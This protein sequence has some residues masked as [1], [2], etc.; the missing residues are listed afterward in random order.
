[1]NNGLQEGKQMAQTKD[2]HSYTVS[3]TGDIRGPPQKAPNPQ[4][5]FPSPGG[6]FAKVLG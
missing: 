1:M 2:R 3:A 5:S 4:E 6:C